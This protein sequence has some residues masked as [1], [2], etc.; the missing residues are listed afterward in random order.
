MKLRSLAVI[1]CFITVLL[2][3]CGTGGTGSSKCRPITAGFTADTDIVY[4]SMN[5]SATLDLTDANDFK[6]TVTSPKLMSGLEIK[7]SAG[8]TRMTF[9]GLDCTGIYDASAVSKLSDVLKTIEAAGET[10]FVDGKC[11]Y[12][13]FTVSVNSN[14]FIDQIDFTDAGLKIN[15]SNQKVK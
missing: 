9:G 14:G 5:Y 12:G 10:E 11:N 4:G 3:G 1:I 6:F 2:C 7:V 15:L 13:D 8:E